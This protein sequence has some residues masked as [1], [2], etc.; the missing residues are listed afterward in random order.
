MADRS[1]PCCEKLIN[2]TAGEL[3]LK[4]ASTWPPLENTTCPGLTLSR[5][6]TLRNKAANQSQKGLLG[7]SP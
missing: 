3:V 4:Q 6:H 1:V 7:L 2:F 5:R